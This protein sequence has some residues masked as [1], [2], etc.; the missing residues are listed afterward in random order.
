MS[1]K[2]FWNYNLQSLH[3]RD[4]LRHCNDKHLKDYLGPHVSNKKMSVC[5][6]KLSSPYL[7]SP[8]SDGKVFICL[9]KLSL[10]VSLSRK[11]STFS[12]NPSRKLK[13]RS[14]MLRNRQNVP[15]GTKPWPKDPILGLVSQQ[16][17]KKEKKARMP[18]CKQFV[19]K[20]ILQN[21]KK[22]IIHNNKDTTTSLQSLS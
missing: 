8:V 13:V 9:E 11:M 12:L 19:L 20:D 3:N 2:I 7:G 18:L 6:E 15:A 4:L 1:K 22:N 5:H 16:A 21:M 10:S 14:K 17:V